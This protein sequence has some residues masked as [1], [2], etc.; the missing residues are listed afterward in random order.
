MLPSANI[1]FTRSLPLEVLMGKTLAAATL[2]WFACGMVG[3]FLVEETRPMTFSDIA[4]GPISLK[5]CLSG[6]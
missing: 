3:G 1:V 5:D 4:W 6:S 2:L